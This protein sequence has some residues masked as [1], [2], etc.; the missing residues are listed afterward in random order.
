[1]SLILPRNRFGL[2]RRTVG[3]AGGSATA[4]ITTLTLASLRSDYGGWVGCKFTVGGAA[5]TLSTLGRWVVSGNS[6]THQVNLRDA[7]GAELAVVTVNTSGAPTGAF[8]YGAITPV[9]LTAGAVYYITS[10]ENS[11]GDQWYDESTVTATSGVTV[12]H[13]CYIGSQTGVPQ[14][15]QAG[16]TYVPVNA[17]YS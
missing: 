17:Q 12:D 10:K 2:L 6:Q 14:I 4:I 9:V 3:S 8:L 11:G 13:G 15:N 7:S 1:M 16:K 5:I